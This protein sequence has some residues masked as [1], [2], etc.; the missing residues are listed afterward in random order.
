MRYTT[1]VGSYPGGVSGYG[2]YDMAGNLWN[3]TSTPFTAANGAEA[4]A[5]VNQVRGGSWYA[6][7]SSA[8]GVDSGE[9]R[10][11]GNYELAVAFQIAIILPTH[12]TPICVVAAPW[13]GEGV[14]SATLTRESL[15]TGDT[16]PANW[17]VS[18]RHFAHRLIAQSRWRALVATP[19]S[20]ARCTFVRSRSQAAVG[21]RPH[22]LSPSP[23]SIR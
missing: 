11:D 7:S 15:A 8:V 2:A 10:A 16:A 4:G 12:R 13:P 1:P 17:S 5:N 14:M 18:K 20:Q 9:G 19:S 22:S 21:N 23:S 3:W 6:T